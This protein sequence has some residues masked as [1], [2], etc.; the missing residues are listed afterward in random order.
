MLQLK[1]HQ[2][3]RL[4]NLGLRGTTSGRPRGS[5]LSA[6][7]IAAVKRSID[8]GLTYEQIIM[9]HGVA[10]NTITRIK[11]GLIE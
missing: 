5:Y 8:E 10:S 7:K 11:R 9:V 2:A 3:D 4:K 6:D 1:Q